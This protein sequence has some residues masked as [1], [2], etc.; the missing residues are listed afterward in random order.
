MP[1]LA[2]ITLLLQIF[3]PLIAEWLRKRMQAKLEKAAESMPEMVSFGTDAAAGIE[4][5][6]DRAVADTPM[7]FVGERMMLRAA[8]RIALARA[9]EVWTAALAGV[10]DISFMPLNSWEQEELAHAVKHVSAE[11]LPRD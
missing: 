1:W 6:F 4:A 11:A 9:G 2:L 8:R 5:L 10:K 3:G 7:I